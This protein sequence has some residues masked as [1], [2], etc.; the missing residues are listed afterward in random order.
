[1]ED[2]SSAVVSRFFDSHSTYLANVPKLSVPDLLA[3]KTPSPMLFALPT[4]EAIAQRFRDSRDA[5]S[6]CVA[7]P[8]LLS[9]FDGVDVLRPG[10]QGVRE[11]VLEV[12]QRRCEFVDLGD[13]KQRHWIRWVGARDRE[14]DSGS[15]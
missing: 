6:K 15:S 9:H 11:K 13:G 5:R 4:E 12:L 1:V 2:V 10:K 3:E 14:W 8:D 7:L